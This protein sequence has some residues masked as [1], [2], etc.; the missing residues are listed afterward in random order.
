MAF[1]DD[2]ASCLSPLPT[3]GQ[4]ADTV[5]DLLDFLHKLHT[6][7]EAAGGNDD[8]LLTALVAGGATGIDEATAAVLAEAAG[9]TVVAYI[10]ACVGCAVVAA[11]PAIWSA[12]ASS[13]DDY[14]KSQLTLAA[15]DKG[16]PQDTATA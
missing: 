16:I 1:A 7:W 10:T 3:P 13:D 12:I 2:F 6:A 5:G 15:N 9:V 11:G 4:L 8:E 14:L